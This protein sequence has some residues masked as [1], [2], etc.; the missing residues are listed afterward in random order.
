MDPAHPGGVT[1]VITGLRD[2]GL[3]DGADL[4]EIWTTRWDDPA[5][6]QLLNA[7][8]AFVALLWALVRR[9]VDLVHVHVSTG[10]STIRKAIF[11]R[12]A[13]LYGVPVVAHLHSGDLE[14]WCAASPRHEAIARSLLG[15]ARVVLVTAPAWAEY[16]KRYGATDVRVVPNGLSRAA[17]AALGRVRDRRS[18]PI[19]RKDEPVV[20]YYG[21]WVD[22]KGPDLLGPA[23]GGLARDQTFHLNV[24]G[25]GDRPWLE[26]HLE[27]IGPR[28]KIGG[29]L[30]EADKEAV[31]AE[32]SVLVVPSRK[33]GFGQVILEGIAAGV[34]IVA[35]DAGAIPSVLQGYEPSMIFPSGN[36]DALRGALATFMWPSE[37]MIA[38]TP[39]ASPYP[40]AFTREHIAATVLDIYREIAGG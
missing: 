17:V 27:P 30:A 9:R 28:A 8:R 4:T 36:V 34:P 7:V 11:A 20:L 31:L 37:A 6:L 12:T 10:G 40:E 24:F 35:S 5:P 18:A 32:A 22:L 19:I 16:P 25:N 39:T 13:R 15:G 33:E 38:A 23:L 1:A 2:A 29:W 21:R 3:S 14:R 26:H